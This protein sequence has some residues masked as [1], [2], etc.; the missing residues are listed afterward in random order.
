MADGEPDLV[1]TDLDVLAVDLG[2][3]ADQFDGA[4][5]LAGYM[6]NTWGQL[7]ANLS[8]NDFADNWK[9]HRGSL[10]DDM[11]KYQEKVQKIDQFWAAGDTELAQSFEE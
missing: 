10:V 9:I 8:M 7:N 11:R 6:W 3:L 4:N 5:D 1:V 2:V